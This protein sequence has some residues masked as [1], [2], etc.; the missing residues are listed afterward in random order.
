MPA[1]S[2]A[3]LSL[4]TYTDAAG[5]TPDG[6]IGVLVSCYE[7]KTKDISLKVDGAKSCLIKAV[8]ADF[9]EKLATEGVTLEEKDG[10]YSFLHLEKD[11]V[12]YLEF[13]I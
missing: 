10:E 6:K 8:G 11:G 4:L 12:Y 1:G 9:D 13:D 5:K 7:C 2:T 3:A